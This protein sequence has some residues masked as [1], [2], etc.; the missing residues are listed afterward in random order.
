MCAGITT[1]LSADL[2]GELGGW[3]K[4][5]ATFVCVVFFFF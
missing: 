5:H 3:M 1:G 4:V 2:E